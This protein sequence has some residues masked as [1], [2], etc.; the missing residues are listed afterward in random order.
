[1]GCNWSALLASD[2]CKALG[3]SWSETELNAIYK[4]KIPASYVR[5]GCLTQEDYKKMLGEVESTVELTGEKP[6][7]HMKKE[8]LLLKARSLGFDVEG[9]AT[10]RADLINLIKSK[11]IA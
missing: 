3:V 8:E 5:Q 1:M 11:S 9:E 4:L 7:V 6:L 10:T 2:R